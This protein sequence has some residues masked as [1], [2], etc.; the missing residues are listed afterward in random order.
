M[1][2]FTGSESIPMLL[3]QITSGFV[4]VAVDVRDLIA[5]AGNGEWGYA[6]Y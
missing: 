1:G 3:G 6:H 5:N 2:D 4:P